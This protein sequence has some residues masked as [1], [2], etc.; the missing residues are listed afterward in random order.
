MDQLKL[1]DGELDIGECD[2]DYEIVKAMKQRP[3]KA[4]INVVENDDEKMTLKKSKLIRRATRTRKTEKNEEQQEPEHE[5]KSQKDSKNDPFPNSYTNNL[6]FLKQ[7]EGFIEENDLDTIISM[8]V[9][10]VND[11]YH[12]ELDKKELSELKNIVY[13]YDLILNDIEEI[14]NGS[15]TKNRVVKPATK[16]SKLKSLLSSY[17]LS[18]RFF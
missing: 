18:A 11:E 6:D 1:Y 5:Q 7:I 14:E 15:I 3:F 8:T 10:E 9:D 4:K 2:G 17:D 12:I 13:T 16:I